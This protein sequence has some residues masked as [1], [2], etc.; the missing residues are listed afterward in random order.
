MTER[1]RFT[2]DIRPPSA[3]PTPGTECELVQDERRPELLVCKHCG[4]V[5]HARSFYSLGNCPRRHAGWGSLRPELASLLAQWDTAVASIRAIP[6][7]HPTPGARLGYEHAQQR[8]EGIEGCARQLRL[9]LEKTMQAPDEACHCGNALVGPVAGIRVCRYCG[10]VWR[11]HEVV[12]FKLISEPRRTQALTALYAHLSALES[13]DSS[14]AA[15]AAWS[16][17][18]LSRILDETPS[19]PVYIQSPDNEVT[20]CCLPLDHEGRCM[21]V[22][23]DALTPTVLSPDERRVWYGMPPRSR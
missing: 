1:R 9:Y 5:V 23:G 6:N 13:S 2:F 22:S 4:A 19:C 12:D 11:A 20:A 15:A 10:R 21:T 7:V 14:Q 16:L 8:A 3:R 18:E 17:K